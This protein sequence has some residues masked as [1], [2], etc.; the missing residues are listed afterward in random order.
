MEGAVDYVNNN[1]NNNDLLTDFSAL[2]I[3]V[4]CTL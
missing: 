1:V 4:N 2:C 3:A